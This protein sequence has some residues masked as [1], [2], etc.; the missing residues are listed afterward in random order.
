MIESD[1]SDNLLTALPD[2]LGFLSTLASLLLQVLV[3]L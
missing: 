3:F 1:V 2:S